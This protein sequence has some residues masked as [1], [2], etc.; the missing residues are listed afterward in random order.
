MGRKYKLKLP[1][2]TSGNLVIQPDEGGRGQLSGGGHYA[3]K[4]ALQLWAL[5]ILYAYV[6]GYIFP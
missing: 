3:H 2:F 5:Y 6:I 4:K 1:V